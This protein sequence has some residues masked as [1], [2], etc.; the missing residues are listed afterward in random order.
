MTSVT[1]Q[2][3]ENFESMPA[4]LGKAISNAGQWAQADEKL[5]EA[6]QKNKPVTDWQQFADELQLSS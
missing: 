3:N 2:Y 5:R 1:L 4:W 6:L